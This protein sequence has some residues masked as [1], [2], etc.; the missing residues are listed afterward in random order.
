M[1]V[2]AQTARTPVGAYPAPLDP[3]FHKQMEECETKEDLFALII[4][5]KGF[6]CPDALNEVVARGL[7]QEYQKWKANED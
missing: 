3:N 5:D 4:S 7:Y 2:K 1:K 6:V